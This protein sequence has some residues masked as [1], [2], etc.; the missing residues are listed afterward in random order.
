MNL[1]DFPVRSAVH[2]PDYVAVR[3][4]SEQPIIRGGRN[5]YPREIRP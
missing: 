1:A 2:Y 3:H 4:D 5:V